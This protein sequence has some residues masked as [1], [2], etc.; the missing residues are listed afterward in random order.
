MKVV[1]LANEIYIDSGSPTNTSIP[2]IAFW[3]RGKVGVI[4]NLLF[5]DF[6]IDQS[7]L[8]IFD[9]NKNE[10]SINAVAIIKQ[11]YKLYDYDLQIRSNLNILSTDSILSVEDQGSKVTKVNRNE[12]S[13]T[14]AQLKRDEIKILNDL[15][16]AYRNNSS[17]PS[18]VVGDDTVVG[19]Y[20]TTRNYIRI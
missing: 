4:N 11:F 19:V 9:A 13:K 6:Y 5:E 2:A 14:L 7:S 17:P 16:N 8:E 20:T 1:D 18:Q 12:I 15:V 10:I 3:I